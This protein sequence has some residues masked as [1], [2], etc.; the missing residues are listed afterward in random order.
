M[1]EKWK[2]GVDFVLRVEVKHEIIKSGKESH[3]P[4]AFFSFKAFTPHLQIV[5]VD[6]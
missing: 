5:L 3:F 1:Y 6:V 2:Y 4:S